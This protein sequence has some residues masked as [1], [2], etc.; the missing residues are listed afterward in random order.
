MQSFIMLS[1][2]NAECPFL[3]IML[4]A[5][6]LNAVMLNIVML[7]VVMLNVIMLGVVMLNVVMPGAVMTNIVAPPFQP[8]LMFTALEVCV[9]KPLKWVGSCL[10][11][12][13]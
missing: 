10:T 13:H 2:T 9:L 12:K 8:N 11:H 1:A 6:M 5:V 7:G 4:C 3:P